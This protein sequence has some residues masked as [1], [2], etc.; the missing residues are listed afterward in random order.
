MW[1]WES[2][3]VK[4][5]GHPTVTPLARAVEENDLEGW[6]KNEVT[7][8]HADYGEDPANTYSDNVIFPRRLTRQSMKEDGVMTATPMEPR[9]SI[10]GIVGWVT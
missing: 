2:D 10:M 7:A 4:K 6:K 3:C 5:Y 9:F 8:F 1:D